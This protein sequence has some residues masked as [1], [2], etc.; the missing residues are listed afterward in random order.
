[1]RNSLGPLYSSMFSLPPRTRNTQKPDICQKGADVVGKGS[2]F[3][4]EDLELS[5]LNALE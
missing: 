3:S 2:I 1:M 4:T 5:K